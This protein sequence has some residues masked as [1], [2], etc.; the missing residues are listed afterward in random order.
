M[1]HLARVAAL[2]CVTLMRSAGKR[3]VRA[4]LCLVLRVLVRGMRSLLVRVHWN[5]HVSLVI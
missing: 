1:L 5:A 4:R 3:R 2:R